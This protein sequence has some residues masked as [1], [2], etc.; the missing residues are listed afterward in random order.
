MKL[1]Y[2]LILGL[3]IVLKMYEVLQY[4]E[5]KY[6]ISRKKTGFKRMIKKTALIY[7]VAVKNLLHEHL[8]IK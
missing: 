7:K 2:S 5:H 1:R 8:N 3:L 4:N 6:G